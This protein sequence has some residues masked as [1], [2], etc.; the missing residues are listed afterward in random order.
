MGWHSHYTNGYRI[1]GAGGGAIRLEANSITLGGQILAN[2]GNGINNGNWDG[3]GGAGG[4]IWIVA[5]TFNSDEYVAGNISANG[6]NTHDSNTSSSD[7]G[8]GGGGGRIAIDVVTDNYTGAV[9]VEPGVGYEGG[10]LP[11]AGTL[12]R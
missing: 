11:Q 5:Q 4:S 7:S 8:S 2:G 12:V 10:D 6:G 3:A 9:L 1:G